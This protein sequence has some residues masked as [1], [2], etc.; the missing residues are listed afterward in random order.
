MGMTFWSLPVF[1]EMTNKRYDAATSCVQ[2]IGL[3]RCRERRLQ[4]GFVMKESLSTEKLDSLTTVCVA[5]F[6][7][8]YQHFPAMGSDPMERN[9]A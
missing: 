3:G 4:N 1:K 7:P 9:G 6:L 2:W 8:S 5:N